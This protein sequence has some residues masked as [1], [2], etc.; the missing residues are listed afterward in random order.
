MSQIQTKFIEDAAVDS[1]KLATDSVVTA[2]IAADNVTDAKIRLANDGYL[3]GRNNANSADVNIL[4]VNTSDVIEFAS[5]PQK[6]GSPSNND[7]LVNKS[8]VD[9]A[10]SASAQVAKEAVEIVSTS[11]LTLS[12]EQ[13]IDGVLTSTS[14]IL[15]AGQTSAD[16]NGIYVTAAG[17]WSRASDMNADS[18]VFR[19]MSVYVDE[20]DV[21]AHTMWVLVTSGPFT[22]DTTNLTFYQLNQWN[23]ED[24]TLNGT[25]ITN[26]Y[27]DLAFEAAPSSLDLFVDG[28][29]QD[30]GSDYTLSVVGGVTRITFAGDLATAGAAAL[31]SGDILR[32]KYQIKR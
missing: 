14:R 30:E 25:D 31:I 2:K 4:K 1:N 5:F 32:V 18:E 20:G 21:Y 3:R 15:V 6:S 22:L 10:V 29:M 28:I 8:Y 11:N 9:G 13:T 17:A 19:G 12:G 26:Q 24:L 16:E 27:K 23:K 7:D